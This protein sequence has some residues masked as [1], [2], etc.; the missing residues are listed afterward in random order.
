MLL[1]SLYLLLFPPR[2]YFFFNL[3]SPLLYIPIQQHTKSMVLI[4]F[5]PIPVFFPFEALCLS[6]CFVIFHLL[7]PFWP[8]SRRTG[9]CLRTTKAWERFDVVPAVLWRRRRKK[10]GTAHYSTALTG[11]SRSYIFVKFAQA[12]VH[13]LVRGG[14]V[15]AVQ[16]LRRCHESGKWKACLLFAVCLSVCLFGR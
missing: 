16:V 6:V 7:L 10:R 9:S 11:F 4:M 15:V 2:H 13:V 5:N 14:G 1:S 8:V 12:L 3:F